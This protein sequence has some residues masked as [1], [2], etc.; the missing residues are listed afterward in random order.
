MCKNCQYIEG[1]F[2][3]AKI[4]KHM[5][6]MPTI[7]L[8]SNLEKQGKIEIIMADCP[9]SE[10]KEV[11]Y[12]ERHYTVLHFFMCMN[13]KTHHR[14]GAC[15]RGTPLYENYITLDKEKVSKTLW[16]KSGSYFTKLN[17]EEI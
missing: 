8:L 15:I 4:D 17:E 16:G 14:I 3:A 6:Y 1:V 7:N 13:C 5:N 9:L 2:K 10:T 11:L 12:S